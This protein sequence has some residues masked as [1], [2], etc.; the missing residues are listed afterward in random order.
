MDRQTYT[1]CRERGYTASAALWHARREEEL[2][3]LEDAGAARVSVEHEPDPFEFEPDWSPRE[4]ATWRADV[5]SG[6]LE[7]LTVLLERR[8]RCPRCGE[9]LAAGWEVVGA[10]GGVDVYAHDRGTPADYVREVARE[11]LE[12]HRGELLEPAGAPACAS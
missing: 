9:Q 5:E 12:E 3:R 8:A 7:V 6:R 1:A 2:E 11:L 10:I 4:R